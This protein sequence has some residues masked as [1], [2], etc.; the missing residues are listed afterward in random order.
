MVTKS[1]VLGLGEVSPNGEDSPVLGSGEDSPV[2]G[3]GEDT[4]PD[5]LGNFLIEHL[6]N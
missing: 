5:R 6:L 2:L 4:H 1:P 3:I